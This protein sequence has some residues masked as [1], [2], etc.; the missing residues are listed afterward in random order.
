MNLL[1][2]IIYITAAFLHAGNHVKGN[3][4]CHEPC[5]TFGVCIEQGP[6]NEQR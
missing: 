6:N 4:E 2:V 5:K 3:Y 1:L